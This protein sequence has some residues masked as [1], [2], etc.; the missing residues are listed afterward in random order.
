MRKTR[1]KPAVTGARIGTPL[2]MTWLPLNEAL[3][4]VRTTVVGALGENRSSR[5]RAASRCV[6][7]PTIVEQ[8]PMPAP[9]APLV[10]TVCGRACHGP[11]VAGDRARLVDQQERFGSAAA[12]ENA[13]GHDRV[14]QRT[15]MLAV[16]TAA[17]AA[18]PCHRC[19]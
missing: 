11:A 16:G 14:I 3:K 2:K 9:T 18:G 4:H 13:A 12:A 5:S 17:P 10:Q 15:V 8:P 7:V 1:A 6:T 19:K